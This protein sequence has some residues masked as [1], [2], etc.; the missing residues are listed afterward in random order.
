MS[1]KCAWYK[2]NPR[3][4]LSKSFVVVVVV[5]DF[6]TIIKILNHE[7]T[8]FVKQHNHQENAPAMCMCSKN[9]IKSNFK[10]NK[11]CTKYKK[12]QCMHHTVVTAKANTQTED[13]KMIKVFES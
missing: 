8:D 7:T 11:R 10:K 12:Q 13:T 6:H 5:Q 3:K 4:L 9:T 2:H 1:T